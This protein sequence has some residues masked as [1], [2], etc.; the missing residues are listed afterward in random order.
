ML[1]NFGGV[2]IKSDNPKLTAKNLFT[3]EGRPE[4]TGL[5]VRWVNNTELIISV[6]DLYKARRINPNGKK[7]ADL[8]VKYEYRQ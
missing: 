4:E 1:F 3:F 6:S 7:S 2:D 5:E 8:T